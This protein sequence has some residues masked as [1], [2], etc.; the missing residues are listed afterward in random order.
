MSPWVNSAISPGASCGTHACSTACQGA[1]LCQN[2]VFGA[3]GLCKPLILFDCIFEKIDFSHSLALCSALPGGVDVVLPA[4]PLALP[5]CPHV[6]HNGLHL[7]ETPEI[8]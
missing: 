8:A 1:R 5:E 7:Q 6:L 2:L 3:C 4:D